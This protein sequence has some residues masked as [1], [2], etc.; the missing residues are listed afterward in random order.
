MLPNFDMQICRQGCTGAYGMQGFPYTLELVYSWAV[1]AHV[2]FERG[3]MAEKYILTLSYKLHKMELIQK[4]VW[5]KWRLS[6]A[7]GWK[8]AR[9]Y[10]NLRRMGG[11]GSSYLL[12]VTVGFKNREITPCK[13]EPNIFR[14]LTFL[15]TLARLHTL[16]CLFR[17]YV[18]AFSY[19][20][21]PKF[22][23]QDIALHTVAC[24]L[25]AKD[26]C[27]LFQAGGRWPGSM[28]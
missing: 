9:I 15:G 21:S 25:G 11:G 10:P 8:D 3:F 16:F 17:E 2:E 19:P 1:S 27:C 20:F 24:Q 14:K 13:M 28:G 18:S 12:N 7:S 4:F 23:C 5:K 6:F 26:I 22:R